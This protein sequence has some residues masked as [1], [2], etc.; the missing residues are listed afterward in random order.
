MKW[1]TLLQWAGDGGSAA[2]DGGQAHGKGGDRLINVGRTSETVSCSQS[3]S[4][5]VLLLSGL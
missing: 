5:S 4:F 1:T 2:D 3:F